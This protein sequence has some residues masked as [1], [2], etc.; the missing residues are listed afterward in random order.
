MCIHVYTYAVVAETTLRHA[1]NMHVMHPFYVSMHAYVYIFMHV[2]KH[3]YIYIYIYTYIHT[4]IHTY[5]Q[6]VVF[7]SQNLE[8]RMHGCDNYVRAHHQCLHVCMY[9]YLHVYVYARTYPHQASNK[10]GKLLCMCMYV[11]MHVQRYNMSLALCV[12]CMCA[13]SVYVHVCMN[14]CMHS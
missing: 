3:I 8:L 11:C 13:S 6:H 7:V 2:S 4:Y 14:S 5:I 9:V 10:Q 12:H 1:C